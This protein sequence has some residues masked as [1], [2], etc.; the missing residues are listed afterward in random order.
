MAFKSKRKK[1]KRIKRDRYGIPELAGDV[2]RAETY[3]VGFGALA[4]AVGRI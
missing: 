3:A 1:K 4:G 2:A